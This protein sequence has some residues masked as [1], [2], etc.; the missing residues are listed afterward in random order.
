MK[1]K[2]KVQEKK[3]FC[4]KKVRQLLN[5]AFKILKT[6]SAN[7]FNSRKLAKQKGGRSYEMKKNFDR[8]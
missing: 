6:S 1:Y 3:D 4:S 2:G 8:N 7:E 5:A